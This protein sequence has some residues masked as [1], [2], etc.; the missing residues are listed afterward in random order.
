MG[1]GQLRLCC[2]A[3]LQLLIASTKQLVVITIFRVMLHSRWK[4][5]CL[6][7]HMGN[8][9]CRRGHIGAVFMEMPF[10]YPFEHPQSFVSTNMFLVYV[11]TLHFVLC[12]L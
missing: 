9:C 4:M 12:H 5:I 1:G 3:L 11:S 8:I 7:K 6:E 10:S 2:L